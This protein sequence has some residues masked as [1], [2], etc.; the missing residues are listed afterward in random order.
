MDR[1]ELLKLVNLSHF[2]A[3]D[4]ETT[5]LDPVSD[6]IIEIAAIRFE[7][8][9]ITDR[10][11]TLVNPDQ[12]ISS[13]ITRI[14]GISNEMVR[15]KPQE[16]QIID[17]LLS[18]LGEDPLVAHNI[19]FDQSFLKSLC[20]RFDKDE[21]SNPLYDTL[22]LGRSLLFDQAVFNLSSL[23]E[24]FGLS[25]KGAHRAE[26]DT[27]NCGLIFLHLVEELGGYPLELLTHMIVG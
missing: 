23:S 24:F 18:F 16:G 11:V 2:I 20:E 1:K 21:V 14:T 26:K 8:G 3:F 25:A 22:Q 5:G 15:N 7:D 9:E 17:E 12:P 27:E 4:F 13:M 10:F 6:R 19:R